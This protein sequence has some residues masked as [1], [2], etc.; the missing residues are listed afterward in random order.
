MR[1]RSR[2]LGAARCRRAKGRYDD[3]EFC[4]SQDWQDGHGRNGRWS[5]RRTERDAERVGKERYARAEKGRHLQ[6][7]DG[8]AGGLASPCIWIGGCPNDLTEREVERAC[9]KFG[10][11]QSISIKSTDRD[12][13][14][15]VRYGRTS[16]AWDAIHALDQTVAFGAGSVRV[17]PADGRDGEVDCRGSRKCGRG[18]RGDGGNEHRDRHGGARRRSRDRSY[19]RAQP[20]RPVRVYLSQL[21]RDMEDDEFQEIVAE[22]GEILQ[23]ELHREGA[24]KCGWVEYASK[25]EAE[26]ALSELD[27]RR[28]DDWNMRLQ[29]YMYPGGGP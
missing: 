13:F 11:V 17:E 19:P 24:Y 4:G 6:D 16:H 26:A 25:G 15:L 27:D 10:P 14:A 1:G 22:Y 29:A 8:D 5:G 28:M 3:A 23:Y 2:S 20:P 9:S 7:C 12:T 21:P 18:R